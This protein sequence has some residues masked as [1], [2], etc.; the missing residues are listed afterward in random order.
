MRASEH[1]P[2]LPDTKSMKIPAAATPTPITV[3]PS[4]MSAAPGVPAAPQGFWPAG[5]W[6]LMELRVGIIPVPV[7]VLIIALT[8]YFLFIGKL[9]TEVCMMM[10]MIA[11]GGFICGELGK[12][13]PVL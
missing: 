8:G 13:L 6:K 7:L 2:N 9:P 10:A 4:E 11:A 3:P 1:A 5:W 12:R